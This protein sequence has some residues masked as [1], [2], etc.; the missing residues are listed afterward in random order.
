MLFLLPLSAHGEDFNTHWVYAPQADSNSHVWFRRA[1][2]SDGRPQYAYITVTTTGYYKLYVNECNVGVS[3]FYPLRETED[4]SAVETTFDI[5]PYLRRD[6]N[7]VA[8]L[9]S[10]VIPSVSHRQISVNIYGTGH[11]GKPFSLN[12]DDSWLCRCANS[13]INSDGGE[14]IDGRQHNTTWKAATI[15]DLALWLPACSF[16]HTW[17]RKQSRQSY[18]ETP[19]KES[20]YSPVIYHISNFTQHEISDTINSPQLPYA[21]IGFVR[22]T[23]REAKKGERITIGNVHYIC[24]G[25]TDEQAFPQFNIGA[26]RTIPITGDSNFSPSQITNLEMVSVAERYAFKSLK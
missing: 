19:V 24:S 12:S 8:I 13:E 15:Y 25:K 9:Y 2:V 11:N 22:A 18:V 7:I 16:H 10:P 1:Y 23:I 17:Q 20:F 21:A 5:S 6:T 14:L 26:W 4:S 3:L